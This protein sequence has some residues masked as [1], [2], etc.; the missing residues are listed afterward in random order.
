MSG[1]SFV[2]CPSASRKEIR[3]TTEPFCRISKQAG[4]SG[5]AGERYRQAHARSFCRRRLDFNTASE[6][7]QPLSDAKQ[8]KMSCCDRPRLMGHIKT[9]AIVFDLKLREA[10]TSADGKTCGVRLCVFRNIDQKFANRAE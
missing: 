4:G 1:P 9:G 2:R 8:T 6:V 3:E 10:T 5:F 7:F